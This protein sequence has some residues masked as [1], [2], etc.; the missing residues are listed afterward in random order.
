TIKSSRLRR[1]AALAVAAAVLGAGGGVRG[2][3]RSVRIAAASDL[4]F[5]L[6]QVVSRLSQVQPALDVQ[7]TYG[8]S[9]TLFAQ[10]VNGAPFDL[11]MSADNDYPKR[12]AARGLALAGSEFTYGIG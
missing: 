11:F 4:R 6:E 3:R 2:E 12:L 8:S 7:V 9:G 5:A 10:L 1:A